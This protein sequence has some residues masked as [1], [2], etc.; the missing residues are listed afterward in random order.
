MPPRPDPHL[1]LP[2]GHPPDVAQIDNIKAQLDLVLLAL[3]AL[4][5][6]GSEAILKAA[7]DLGLQ[8]LVS[9]RVGL[10][11]LRQANPLRKGTGGRKKLDI[12]EARSLVMISCHLAQGH[13]DMIREAVTTLEDLT[14][15]N[16]PPHQAAIL[17][18]YLDRFT[19][20]YQER[21][22]SEQSSAQMLSDLGLRLLIDLL[23]YSSPQGP[24]RL[25]MVLL[26]RANR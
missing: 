14:E 3:E 7:A 11:R 22:D 15:K 1:S 20:T 9:D 26:D 10:W 24:R 5:G 8:D 4:T 2:L 23:F 19:N 16:R 6:I 18:D 12:E 25:W 13:Q 17:G 21:M